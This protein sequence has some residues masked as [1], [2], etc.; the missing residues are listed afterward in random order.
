[1]RNITLIISMW[2]LSFFLIGCNTKPSDTLAK[3]TFT[4]LIADQ[5]KGC[6]ALDNFGKVNG[7][8]MEVSGIKMY[9]YEYS[10]SIK[11]QKSCYK[12]GDVLTGLFNEFYCHEKSSEFSSFNQNRFFKDALVTVEGE[13]IFLKK[14]NGW[15]LQKNDA[16]KW[17]VL[18]NSNPLLGSWKL[19]ESKVN[20]PY[21]DVTRLQISENAIDFFGFGK[22]P[23][24]KIKVNK[25][26][27][28]Y[29][30]FSGDAP[31]GT[32][33]GRFTVTLSEDGNQVTFSVPGKGEATFIK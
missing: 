4:K 30:D 15:E 14:E 23:G 24:E 6:I 8:L 1:M 22:G 26:Y 19:K 27:S 17:T 10:A 20:N 18:K 31:P 12:G 29:Y 9:T 5:S 25:E 21:F 2:M 33:V 16:K 32:D 13:L 28:G 7:T 3:E 11:F